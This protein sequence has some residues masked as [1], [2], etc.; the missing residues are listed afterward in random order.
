MRTSCPKGAPR[1]R[2]P[3]RRSA[4]WAPGP[5][6]PAPVDLDAAAHGHLCHHGHGFGSCLDLSRVGSLT[7]PHHVDGRLSH[8]HG[9][10]RGPLAG[11]FRILH[12]SFLH[13]F[14]SRL[15]LAGFCRM[16]CPSHLHDS[17]SRLPP[18][19]PCRLLRLFR[20]RS[21]KSRPPPVGLC[22]PLRPF[23]HRGPCGRPPL[24]DLC[25]LLRLSCHS[26]RLRSSRIPPLVGL[27][28]LHRLFCH[29]GSGSCPGDC[30]DRHQTLACPAKNHC[31]SQSGSHFSLRDTHSY[32]GHPCHHCCMVHSYLCGVRDD[33]SQPQRNRHL[34]RRHANCRF[35]RRLASHRHHRIYF[36]QDHH[37]LTRDAKRHLGHYLELRSWHVHPWYSYRLRYG[38]FARSHFAQSLQQTAG[39][40][41]GCD[42]LCPRQA[43]P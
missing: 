15:P 26:C 33:R 8:Q 12:L 29:H 28:P 22:R 7:Q 24:S 1:K 10:R 27:C 13:D 32:P 42:L 31:P 14:Y 3:C 38:C 9:S 6:R 34:H 16:L 18:A 23:C 30:V 41:L 36:G 43:P 4:P 25:R 37:A 17:C 35:C 19:D 11:L 39:M 2:R 5:R 21:S 20:R 40:P